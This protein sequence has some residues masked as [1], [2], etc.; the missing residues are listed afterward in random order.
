M[1]QLLR[2]IH[3]IAIAVAAVVILAGGVLPMLGGGESDAVAKMETLIQELEEKIG[4]QALPP[5]E[6]TSRL[7]TL[8]RRFE[9]AERVGFG[10]WSF[11]RK[12]ATLRE[13]KEAVKTPPVHTLP[14]V[15]KLTFGRDA[16]T[17]SAFH[18]LSG[19]LGT[20]KRATFVEA[21]VQRKV[22]GKD[23]EDLLN[24]PDAKSEG[25]FEVK[26]PNDEN[27][28][29]FSYRVRT[30]AKPEAAEPGFVEVHLS[31]AT[32]PSKPALN[33]T[34]EV[35]NAVEGSIDPET[36]Q[37]KPGSASLTRHYYD[38]ATGK[39]EKKSATVTEPKERS[40]GGWQSGPAIAESH[41][42]LYGILVDPKKPGLLVVELRN[43]NDRDDKLL[44][45][46]GQRA[47]L[48]LTPP[49]I[50]MPPLESD[51]PPPGDLPPAGAA[52]PPDGK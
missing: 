11:Y 16:A 3:K 24:I 12:P 41:Y 9:L 52:S 4:K 26:L 6:Y 19:R 47:R 1:S 28:D 33:S 39:T 22:D 27:V 45:K 2:S 23:W 20:L 34:W 13:R 18:T 30:K 42:R 35:V 14:D 8:E 32:P 21:V 38:Y 48:P 31:R 43:P 40:G 46:R 25:T 37:P 7:G 44:L 10:D 49:N 17:K 51:A 29:E 5:T 36:D 15:T 50:E